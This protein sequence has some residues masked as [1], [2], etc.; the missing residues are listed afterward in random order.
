MKWNEFRKSMY[1]CIVDYVYEIEIFWSI[2]SW[3]IITWSL[4]VL[5]IEV[6]E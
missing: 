6:E 5:K 1:K 2:L 3:K 4:S